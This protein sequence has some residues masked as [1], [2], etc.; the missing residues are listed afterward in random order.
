M[1]QN[2]LHKRIRHLR[3][4]ARREGITCYRVYDRDI[5]EI[6]LA[7]DWYEGH[8]HISRFQ[9]AHESEDEAHAW[10]EAMAQAAAL[11]L[12]VPA[13]RVHV[14]ERR[15]G[16][17]QYTR[18]D[19]SDQYVVVGEGGHRFAVN[20]DDYLDTGLFLDHRLTRARIQ[21]EARGAHFLNLFCYTGSFTVYAAAGGARRTVSV[22]LSQRYLAWAQRNLALNELDSP[23]HELVRADVLELLRDPPRETFDLA[24]LDPPTFSN[25]KRMQGVL[26]IQRDHVELIRGTLAL[27]RRGGVLYMS[28]NARRFQLDVGAIPAA[29]IDDITDDTIPEDFRAHR[30]HRCWR[31]VR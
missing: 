10:L 25:S 2:R 7:I 31:I 4:W 16:R 19:D 23:A 8:L 17:W 9:R 5:P 13:D 18:L 26:D 20:L 27:L 3:K 15:R 14:K 30:P 28:T 24:V 6:P 22:D 11:A 21:R 12:E 1:L 29:S